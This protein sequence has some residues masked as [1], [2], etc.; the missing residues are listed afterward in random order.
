MEGEVI[1]ENENGQTYVR[2]KINHSKE[3]KAKGFYLLMTNGNTY[4]DKKDEFIVE[5]R[6]LKILDNAKIEYEELPLNE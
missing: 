2:I 3:N 5:K 4:S 1:M 6:F